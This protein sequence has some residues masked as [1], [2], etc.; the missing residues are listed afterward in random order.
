MNIFGVGMSPFIMNVLPCCIV[1]FINNRYLLTLWW[2]SF[3][4]GI[5]HPEQNTNAIC[6]DCN[7]NHNGNAAH[8]W[9]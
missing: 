9:L 4:R 2:R 1:I 6:H 5:R 3:Y 8:F 7:G